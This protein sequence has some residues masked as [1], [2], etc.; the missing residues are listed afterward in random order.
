MTRSWVRIPLAAPRSHRPSLRGRWLLLLMGFWSAT[1]LQLC[2]G[3]SFVRVSVSGGN[4][5]AVVSGRRTSRGR[6]FKFSPH[7][8]NFHLADAFMRRRS[9]RYAVRDPNPI[10]S[11]KKRLAPCGRAVFSFGGNRRKR[12]RKTK[13]RS[14]IGE[15]P[16]PDRR[17]TER[18]RAKPEKNR[19]KTGTK[20]RKIGYRRRGAEEASSAAMCATSTNRFVQ[21]DHL[22]QILFN[23]GSN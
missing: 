7:G 13:K 16:K 10:S 18:S 6:P 4:A 22:L 19:R 20:S 23:D 14:R 2:S 5:L 8:G 15:K 17:K 11:S 12:R 9:R 3:R 21:N 1:N